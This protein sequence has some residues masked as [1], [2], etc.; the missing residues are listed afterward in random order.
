M[1]FDQEAVAMVKP[2]EDAEDAAKRLTQEAYQRGSADNITSVVVRFLNN[3]G[4]SSCGASHPQGN[5][6]SVQG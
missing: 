1:T 4:A 6:P 5:R 2:I 3:Q